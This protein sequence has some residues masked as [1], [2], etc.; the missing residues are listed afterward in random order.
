M[1]Y[2]WKIIEAQIVYKSLSKLGFLY[3]RS[4][5]DL[6]GKSL[7][8]TYEIWFLPSIIDEGINLGIYLIHFIKI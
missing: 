5:I 3:I 6:K 1:K 4:K 8:Q 2:P 7:I